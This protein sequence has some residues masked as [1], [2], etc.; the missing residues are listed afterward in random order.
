M[1][2]TSIIVIVG[3]LA[4]QVFAKALDAFTF[5]WDSAAALGINVRAARTW[6]L[7]L[8]SLI[9]AAAVAASGAIAF[10]G[11][12][13][14]HAVRLLAGPRHGTLLPLS[15]LLG[16]VFLMIVDTFARSA[17][18]AHEFPAGVITALLG[19]PAFALILRRVKS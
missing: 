1:I 14:P 8:T 7:V 10:V 3:L 19:A 16:A 6:L 2:V 4:I 15:A 13:I 18:G 12:L 9:T 11:L 17:F 5:G